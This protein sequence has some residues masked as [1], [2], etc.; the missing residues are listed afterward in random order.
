MMYM[1]MYITLHCQ[2]YAKPAQL[3]FALL[4]LVELFHLI[5]NS[6]VLCIQCTIQVGN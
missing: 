5:F 6:P 2:M 3:H 4:K 1:Y